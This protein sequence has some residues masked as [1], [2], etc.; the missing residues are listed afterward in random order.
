M[1]AAH[2]HSAHVTSPTGPVLGQPN[3]KRW[4]VVGDVLN[5]AK[6]AFD[7][8]KRLEECGRTVYRVSPYCKDGSCFT[9]LDDIAE[10]IDAVNLIVSPKIGVGVLDSMAAKGIKYVFIQPGAEGGDVLPRAASL[11]LTVQ[12]GCVLV[13]PLPDL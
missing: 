10:P 5:A 4:A 12:Q 9:S 3:L 2:S 11:D 1:S 6:P 8:C 13:T 7:V